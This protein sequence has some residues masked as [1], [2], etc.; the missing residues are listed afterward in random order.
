MSVSLSYLIFI[1]FSFGCFIAGNDN[2]WVFANID[3]NSV[4]ELFI[5][6]CEH[7]LVNM[8]ARIIL[9]NTVRVCY[10][11]VHYFRRN[12]SDGKLMFSMF[13]DFVIHLEVGVPGS[14]LLHFL[15]HF[16]TSTLRHFDTSTLRLRSVR[17]FAQCGASL[18]AALRSVRRYAQ[19]SATLSALLGSV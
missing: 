12:T 18:S 5:V 10:Y 15:R 4:E 17:R 2:V 3:K 19:C 11:Q 7:A 8:F 14:A 9:I 1:F 16:G 6:F 13:R